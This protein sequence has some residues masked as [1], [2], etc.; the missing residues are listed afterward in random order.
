MAAG[1]R[2]T[3]EETRQTL[4]LYWRV[5]FGQMHQ[6]NPIVIA[7]AKAIDRTP[8]SI[9]MKLVNFAS[10]DPEITKTGRKGLD[11]ATALDR[12]VWAEFHKR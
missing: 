3:E 2:W 10:L 6:H 5:P 4:D 1:R 11:G 12:K 7:H 8:S 9:A